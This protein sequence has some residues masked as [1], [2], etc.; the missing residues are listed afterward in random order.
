MGARL[1]AR[2]HHHAGPD[3]RGP[4][5]QTRIVPLLNRGEECIGISVQDRWT[6]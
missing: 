4:A 5:S 3:D 2:G 1:V 6:L